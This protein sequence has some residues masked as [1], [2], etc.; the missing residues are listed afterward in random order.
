MI[1][2]AVVVAHGEPSCN[3]ALGHVAKAFA[4]KAVS[5]NKDKACSGLKKGPIGIDKTTKLE[6]TKFKLC[7]DGPVVSAEIAVDIRCSTSSAA[8][9]PTSLPEETITATASADLDSCRILEADVSAPGA[10]VEAGIEIADLKTKLKE[11]AEK[12]IK[13]YCK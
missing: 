11:A 8:T 1:I 13:R 7:E 4:E 10:L 2:S 5:D 9:F 12:E 6:L 3:T